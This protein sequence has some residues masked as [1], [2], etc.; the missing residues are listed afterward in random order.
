M[1]TILENNLALARIGCNGKGLTKFQ[2]IYPFT[3]ENISG[4]INAFNLKDRSLL[5]IGSSGDQ[6]INAVFKGSKDITLLDIN[7]FTKYYYYLK[8][9]ALLTLSKEEYLNFFRLKIYDNNPLEYNRKVLNKE[10]FM[11]IGKTLIAIDEDS[12]FFWNTLLDEFDNIDVRENLFSHDEDD[13]ATIVKCNPYLRSGINYEETKRKI[14]KVTPTFIT[15]NILTHK[16]NRSY[17]SIWLS[18]L[19]TYLD[20]SELEKLYIGMNSHLTEDGKILLRYMYGTD[21]NEENI[22]IEFNYF[23]LHNPKVYS[24]PSVLIDRS[25]SIIYMKKKTLGKPIKY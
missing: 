9:A 6:V 25:D 8:V 4:Y 15:D 20:S 22:E 16:L 5:T 2:H 12:F 14:K 23:S 1:E 19:G 11:K 21:Y 3:T 17:D 13:K 24:F 18:N 7:P 10:T